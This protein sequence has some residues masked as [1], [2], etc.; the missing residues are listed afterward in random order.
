MAIDATFWVAVSFIIFFGGLV[1]YR[2]LNETAKSK[3]KEN[4]R[5]PKELKDKLAEF[6]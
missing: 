3:K 1:Y 6:E 5:I 4:T 2:Y